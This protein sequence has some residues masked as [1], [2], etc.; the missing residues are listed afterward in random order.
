MEI[1]VAMSREV[2][3]NES[4]VEMFMPSSFCMNL[5]QD[6]YFQILFCDLKCWGRYV[7]F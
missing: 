5:T 3:G 4:T 6:M 2:T 1:S 7:M